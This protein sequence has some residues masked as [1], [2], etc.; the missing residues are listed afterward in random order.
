V[1]GRRRA[2]SR[3]R[4]GSSPVWTRL[5]R[6]LSTTDYWATRLCAVAL[7]LSLVWDGVFRAGWTVNQ[8]QSTGGWRRARLVRGSR[9]ESARV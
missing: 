3:R 1:F 9:R 8:N 6:E 2:G 4:R 7:T 5:H